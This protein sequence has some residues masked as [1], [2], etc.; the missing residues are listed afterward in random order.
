MKTLR[1]CESCHAELPADSTQRLCPACLESRDAAATSPPAKGLFAPPSAVALAPYFPQLEILDLLGFGGMGAVYRARQRGLGRVV[2]LKILPPEVSGDGSFA[3]RFAREARTLARL[4]HPNIVT[5]FDLGQSGPYYYFL[6]E[7]V[8]GA[9]LRQLL[10]SRKLASRDAIALMPQICEALECAHQEGVI[11]RDIKPENVLVDSRGRVK[12]ADFGLSKLFGVASAGVQLTGGTAGG[13]GR[14]PHPRRRPRIPCDRA[15]ERTSDRSGALP[16]RARQCG[17][18]RSAR[19]QAAG[20][21][22]IVHLT[23][24]LRMPDHPLDRRKAPAQASLDSVDQL[25]EHGRDGAG[26]IDVAMEIH[27]LAVGGVAHPYVVDIAQH[28][29][30][31]RKLG[32]R[33]R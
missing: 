24:R 20:G 29:A 6:M 1:I 17:A 27:D 19:R 16:A 26:R 33:D 31:R 5:V 13:L 18:R 11:H 4:S 3:E 7:F 10:Q 15:Q 9:N 23:A 8:D 22:G 12:V 14:Q 28:P 25:V 2:A 32:E 30:C 21:G